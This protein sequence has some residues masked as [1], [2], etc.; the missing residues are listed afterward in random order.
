MMTV[1]IANIL[2]L[3]FAEEHVLDTN[4]FF[5]SETYIIIN[6]AFHLQG[7][8]W[9]SHITN[10]NYCRR[11][12]CLILIQ[13]QHPEMELLYNVLWLSALHSDAINPKFK[14]TSWNVHFSAVHH[15]LMK[16]SWQCCGAELHARHNT[17]PHCSPT[18]GPKDEERTPRCYFC[19]Q[20]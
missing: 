19:F 13:A 10:H 11:K 2:L 6:S 7:L 8:L 18:A 5:K 4:L 15:S 9:S 17:Y 14:I 3:F 12:G 16:G 1:N 20:S